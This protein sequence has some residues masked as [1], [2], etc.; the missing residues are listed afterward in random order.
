MEKVYNTFCEDIKNITQNSNYYIAGKGWLILPST[1]EES[2][3][4]WEEIQLKYNY[5]LEKDALET[6]TE[7]R[8]VK[9]VL[10]QKL[11]W[12]EIVNNFSSHIQSYRKNMLKAHNISSELTGIRNLLDN[13]EEAPSGKTTKFLAMQSEKLG[14][15]LVLAALSWLKGK[16]W[17]S[18]IKPSAGNTF[19]WRR[20]SGDQHPQPFLYG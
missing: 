19:L 4:K 7:E 5:L 8:C 10:A 13:L 15:V 11:R 6:S 20:P 14:H 12:L 18:P 16:A 17:S 2:Q 9:D 3:K 1:D